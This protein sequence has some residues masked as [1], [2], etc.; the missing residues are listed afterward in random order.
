MII[1]IVLA[2]SIYPAWNHHSMSGEMGIILVFQRLCPSSHEVSFS[3]FPLSGF[4]MK[5]YF[6]PW[7]EHQFQ[8]IR[9]QNRH[10]SSVF[11]SSFLLFRTW[12][13]LFPLSYSQTLNF[14]FM[15][16]FCTVPLFY[17]SS[18]HYSLLNESRMSH[19]LFA[20]SLQRC[21]YYL[22]F[23]ESVHNQISR[24]MSSRACT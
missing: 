22:F 15:W 7:A 20:N 12:I 4:S 21:H 2:V 10:H 11:S 18:L 17:I 6:L 14:S 16:K 8:N 5:S 3:V 13:I 23:K 19:L 24:K 1:L 9:R